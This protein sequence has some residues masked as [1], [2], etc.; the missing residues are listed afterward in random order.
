MQWL[1]RFRFKGGIHPTYHKDRTS[2]RSI[3]RLP[4]PPILILPLDQH[5]GTPAEA[6]VRPGQEVHRG[7][8]I[9]R[10][11]GFVSAPIHAPH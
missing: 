9:A 1:R 8:L 7:E 2:N 4:F 5:I 3:K 11:N 10:A 6:I